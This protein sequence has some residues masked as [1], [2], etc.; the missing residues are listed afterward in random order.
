MI[1]HSFLIFPAVYTHR[2]IVVPLCPLLRDMLGRVQHD[3]RR[4]RALPAESG[5][6]TKKF[7]AAVLRLS[8]LLYIINEEHIPV[9]PIPITERFR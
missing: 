5:Y 6:F 3:R 2:I 8:A 7:I 4:R 9:T 1:I